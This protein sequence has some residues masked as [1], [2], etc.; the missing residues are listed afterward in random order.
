M[1]AALLG[2]GSL[3]NKTASLR[4]RSQRQAETPTVQ[5]GQGRQA[6]FQHSGIVWYFLATAEGVRWGRTRCS[7]FRAQ[8]FSKAS[9][10]GRGQPFPGSSPEGGKCFSPSFLQTHLKLA[11]EGGAHSCLPPFPSK[12]LSD[13]GR[14]CD[15][16]KEE[17][18]TY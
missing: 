17:P 5:Q 10:W 4:S 8:Q 15:L 1:K 11:R 9:E 13:V 18:A 6:D 2:K 16:S 12:R 7:V 14:V 3:T